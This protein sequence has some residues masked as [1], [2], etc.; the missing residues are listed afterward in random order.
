MSDVP[1]CVDYCAGADLRELVERE[2]E[3][4]GVRFEDAGAVFTLL[5]PLG[6]KGTAGSFHYDHSLRVGLVAA[7]IAEHQQGLGGF[8]IEPKALLLAGLLH[9][10]GKAL[11]PACTLA[12]T[13]RWTEGDQREMDRHVLDGFRILR[14]RFDFT[15][16]VIAWHHRHQRRPYP[17]ELPEPLQPFSGE[18]LVQIERCGWL[19][20]MADVYDALHR[21]NSATGGDALSEGEIRERMHE[22]FKEVPAIV[23]DLYASGV[24][25]FVARN[26]HPGGYCTLGERRCHWC[27]VRALE[28]GDHGTCRVCGKQMDRL[29]G[30][31]YRDTH[32]RCRGRSSVR[33]E[34]GE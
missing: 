11:V 12:A 28:T 3:R 26:V 21:V 14:D 30:D 20:A 19:L 25:P 15:A 8:G 32:Y 24:L 13:R 4:L 2:M 22:S 33:E 31:P 34:Q 9:D 5:G 27:R 16:H 29:P 1:K 18:T 17:A 23:D 10:V 7:R 6:E